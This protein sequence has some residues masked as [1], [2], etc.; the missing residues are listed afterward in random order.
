MLSHEYFADTLAK[1]KKMEISTMLDR[2]LLA[3]QACPQSRS[4]LRRLLAFAANM[5]PALGRTAQ[6]KNPN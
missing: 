2:E 3:A 5:L 1:Q 6:K 4:R